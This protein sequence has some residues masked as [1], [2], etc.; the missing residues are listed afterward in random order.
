MLIGDRIKV[1][2]KFNI[3]LKTTDPQS[4]LRRIV[5]VIW[6]GL[7]GLL[8]LLQE[9]LE[10]WPA[11]G[12]VDVSIRSFLQPPLGKSFQIIE[13][14]KLPAVEQIL[15]HILKRRFNFSLCLSHQLHPFGM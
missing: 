2:L 10:G 13:I 7:K 4:H 8:L 1:G 12:V 3:P 9:Q 14:L 5:L 11:G 6:E 15:F